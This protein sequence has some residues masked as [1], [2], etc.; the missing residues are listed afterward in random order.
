[1]NYYLLTFTA[2]GVSTNAYYG[3][4][5]TS[6]G[7]FYENGARLQLTAG[8]ACDVTGAEH[9]VT[10]AAPAGSI[11]GLASLETTSKVVSGEV[12]VNPAIDVDIVCILSGMSGS[13]QYV[14]PAGKKDGTFSFDVSTLE[15]LTK[16]GVENLRTGRQPK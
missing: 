5:L 3:I 1:M 10:I 9:Y 7:T 16:E 6:D 4:L 13:F 11:E 15:P 14:L 2:N 12:E 8:G